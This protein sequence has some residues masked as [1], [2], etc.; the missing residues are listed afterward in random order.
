MVHCEFGIIVSHNQN[1]SLFCVGIQMES[2]L[3]TSTVN[4]SHQGVQIPQFEYGIMK[5][6]SVK[7]FEDTKIGLIQCILQGAGNGYFLEVMIRQ[8]DYWISKVEF[9]FH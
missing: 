6:K 9:W 4:F 1:V 3:Y 2:L 7:F 5:R 8:Y